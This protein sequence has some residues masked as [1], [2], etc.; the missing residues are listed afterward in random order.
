[1][2]DTKDKYDD[3]IEMLTR[4]GDDVDE[5]GR[6]FTDRVVDAWS[7]AGSEGPGCLFQT[8]G[9]RVADAAPRFGHP[10]CG[11]LTQI[12]NVPSEYIACTPEL[13]AE[14]LADERIPKNPRRITPDDLEV[15]AEWQR[16]LDAL[17][18]PRGWVDADGQ[19]ISS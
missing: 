11:C 16:K 14:I 3:A 19:E 15:F 6:D 17:G 10:V 18:I 1:M 4:D 7:D 13:T 12:R 2:N 5:D 8:V 9:S